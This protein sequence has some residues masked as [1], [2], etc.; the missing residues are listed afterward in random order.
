MKKPLVTFE[1]FVNKKGQY[2]WRAVHRNKN[3]IAGNLEGVKNKTDLTR[4]LNNF[5]KAIKVDSFVIADLTKGKA[6]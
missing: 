5:I 1:K 4:S 2:Q 3:V 6:K